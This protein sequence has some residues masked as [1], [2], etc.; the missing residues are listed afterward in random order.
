MR[1]ISAK[2]RDETFVRLASYVAQEKVRRKITQ[3]EVIDQAIREFFER[4]EKKD[5]ES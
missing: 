1:Q 3:E 5:A 4:Q 2:I